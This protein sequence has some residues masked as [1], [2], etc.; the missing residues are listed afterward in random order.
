MAEPGN[1][2]ISA[3]TQALA[4]QVLQRAAAAPLPSEITELETEALACEGDMTPAEIRAL[5]EAALHQAQQISRLMTRLADLLDADHQP[6]R[7]RG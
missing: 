6:D 3:E 4:E 2:R 1:S 5:A 7:A